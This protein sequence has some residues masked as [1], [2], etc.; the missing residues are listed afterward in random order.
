MILA[1]CGFVLSCWRI[2]YF[3]LKKNRVFVCNDSFQSVQ[4]T[5]TN[6]CSN[7]FCNIKQLKVYCIVNI[8]LTWILCFE[9]FLEV[10]LW[11]VVVFSAL[12]I[13]QNPFH[14]SPYDIIK[15]FYFLMQFVRNLYM[16]YLGNLFSTV[17]E[18][19]YLV[20]MYWYVETSQWDFNAFN[21][22]LKNIHPLWNFLNCLEIIFHNCLQS[23]FI[24]LNRT[25]TSEM[26]IASSISALWSLALGHW[27]LG[28]SK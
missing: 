14:I 7:G 3:L 10:L 17:W 19:A 24:K 28:K 11:K 12:V 4:L 13:I 23:I 18:V 6:I 15:I 26:Q 20:S 5:T 25:P 2:T 8:A 9:V 1:A 27:Y 16:E 22:W 21:C